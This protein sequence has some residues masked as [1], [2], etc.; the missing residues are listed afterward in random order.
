M[1]PS[2]NLEV[3]ST[4]TVRRP[5]I[6]LAAVALTSS[7][8]AFAADYDLTSDTNAQFYDVR[9]PTGEVVYARRR[10]TTTLGVGA[11]NLV[12]QVD[13]QRLG[14]D[15]S[16]VARVRYDADYGNGGFADPNDYGQFVPGL[17]RGPVDIMYAYLEGR[18]LLK[19]WVSFRAG[20]QYVVDPLGWWSF[21]GALAKVASP[22]HVALEG[23]GGFEV[24]GGLPLST[25]RFEREGVWRGDRNG[26][27]PTLYPSFQPTA[28][29]PAFGASVETAGFSWLQARVSYRRVYNTGASNLSQFQS[30][31]LTPAIYDGSRTSQERIGG[32]LN[33]N[34][35]NWGGLKSGMVYDLYLS[36]VTQVFASADVYATKKVTLSADYDYYQPSFD[37]D[38]IWNFFGAEPMNYLAL[39][40][41]VDA[42][43][44]FS[45]SAS[46]Y[47]RV[48]NV[49]TQPTRS[50]SSP[51]L[52]DFY[53]PSIYPANG[54]P[55]DAGGTASLRYRSGSLTIGA[56]GAGN[57][58]EGGQ[59]VGGDVYTEKLLGHRYI[60]SG[61][62]SLWAWD[63]KLRTNRDSVS[64]GYMA[65]LGYVIAQR[66]KANLEFDHYMN[67]LVGHRFRLVL[68]LNV[69]VSP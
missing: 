67:S 17:S 51:G 32:S 5:V 52:T 53:N 23:Y 8:S 3:V 69:A 40:A 2:P 43:E 37:A 24:R 6:A 44:K 48:F 54:T 30:G 33:F 15:L 45:V 36:N 47:G 49:Q 66:S 12:K 61:R 58:G 13:K 27:D 64:G 55:F 42:T 1:L 35:S 65:G 57:F 41:N 11:Y 10:V 60:L 39:R 4:P 9:S 28:V 38:S 56:K 59:R 14:P 68:S 7:V 22:Y 29:A 16:F 34:L 50:N 63:D 18:R 62:A 25:G 20:R 26:Y 31:L 21:D 46:G 19:G